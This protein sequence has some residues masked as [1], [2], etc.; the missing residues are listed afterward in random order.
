[1]TADDR[2]AKT[3]AFALKALVGVV[4]TAALFYVLFRYVDL[5]Q[6]GALLAR[7]RWS[8]WLVGFGVWVLIYLGR[9]LRFLLLAP[10]TPYLT[11][12]AITA[13]HNFLL[14][15]LP[16]RTGEL[17][18]ALLVRR[19]GTAGLGESVI[20]LVLLRI[21]DSL[22]V[23]VLF[24]AALGVDR[25]TYLGDRRVGLAAAA[26]AVA[27]GLVLV[28]ALVPAL[29]LALR[30]CATLARVLGLAQRGGVQ[31]VLARA[32]G[33]IDGF[34]Q[35]RPVAIVKISGVSVALWLLT[36]GGFFAIMRAF[37]MPVGVAQTVLGSTAAVVVGFLPIGGIGS[38]GT[39]EAGW[40]LGFALVG[41]EQTRAVASGFG[42]SISTFAYG[43]VLGLLGW[44]GL[45]IIG[46]R[47]RPLGDQ[48]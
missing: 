14:R 2:S 31:R 44:I 19:A 39:L 11:M 20:G 27:L 10:R 23:V 25:G 1:V 30:V 22:T 29:R 48:R 28:V 12:L 32:A 8:L 6:I 42:V 34:A 21:I 16:L 46:K 33:A 7:T 17:S 36:F 41:L 13:V 18:Y 4:I 38:F 35:L 26:V 43:A 15:L 45:A 24:A 3:R 40:A 5:Q 47:T 9:A 37:S